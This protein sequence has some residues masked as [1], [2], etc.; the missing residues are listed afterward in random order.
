MR[1]T[2]FGRQGGT[3]GIVCT[4]GGG[5]MSPAIQFLPFPILYLHIGVGVKGTDWVGGLI[6]FM[7]SFGP[8]CASQLRGG[9][10]DEVGLG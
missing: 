3:V 8:G 1:G 5:A 10:C 9:S 4:A 7:A 2:G 6:R